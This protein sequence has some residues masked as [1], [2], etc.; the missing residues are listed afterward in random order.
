MDHE[1][2]FNI[3]RKKINDKEVLWLLWEII[4]SDPRGIPIGNL[5]SQLFANVYLHELDRFIKRELKERYYLRYMDDFLI[6]GTDKRRL[7]DERERIRVFLRDTLKLELHPKKSEVF[8]IDDGIDFLG[9]VIRGRERLLRKSTVK[10][11]MKKRRRYET[12]IRMGK[13]PEEDLAV[14]LTSWRGYMKFADAYALRKK[15][16]LEGETKKP[17]P[18]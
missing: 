15:L 17:T 2:L 12:L 6:L 9:Y 8:P 18:W 1:I 13:A 7:R 14:A 10:R 5:T 3:L 11:I 4:K 16:G